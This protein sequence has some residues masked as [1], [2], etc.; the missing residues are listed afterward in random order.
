MRPISS[1]VC[2]FAVPDRVLESGLT[3]ARKLVTKPTFQPVTLRVSRTFTLFVLVFLS[4]KLTLTYSASLT[5]VS[6]GGT[7]VR[8]SSD[9]A[10]IRSIANLQQY[11]GSADQ[12]EGRSARAHKLLM[13]VFH[14]GHS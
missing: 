12:S 4:L 7:V 14:G 3:D 1:E 9:P 11:G 8:Q 5:L 10:P 13:A 2:G 6:R